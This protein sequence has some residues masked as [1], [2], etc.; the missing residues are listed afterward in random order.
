[1]VELINYSLITVLP[2]AT[3]ADSHIRSPLYARSSSG[4]GLGLALRLR[5]G[6]G[7]GIG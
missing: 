5:L 2:V 7:L 1:M 4:L 3:S 6:I